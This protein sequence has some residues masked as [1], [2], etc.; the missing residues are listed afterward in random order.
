MCSPS[1]IIKRPPLSSTA[2]RAGWIGCNF[3]L[4]RIPVEVRI[5]IVITRSSGRESAPISSGESRESQSRLTSAATIIVSPEAVREK[6]KRV[7]PLKDISVTQ[8]GWT[9]DVLNA[10][11]RLAKTEFTTTDAY[12]FTRELE[13]LHPDNSDKSRA[14]RHVRDNPANDTGQESGSNSKSCATSDCYCT[15]SVVSGGLLA[16]TIG[17][18]V[19]LIEICLRRA[20][21]GGAGG[22]A[23][24][25]A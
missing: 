23:R 1:A 9:L 10:I 17:A 21:R 22:L 6:F 14:G 24:R 5:A 12:A 4:N 15:S 19:I 8:R 3:A 7:K 25:S 11:R 13:K 16:M 2:R 18:A 20:R